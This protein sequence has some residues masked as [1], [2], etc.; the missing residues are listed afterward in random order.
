[1]VW[2]L[3]G[4]FS[5][6]DLQ[7]NRADPSGFG[8]GVKRARRPSVMRLLPGVKREISW[9]LAGRWI[10]HFK[11]LVMQKIMRHANIQTT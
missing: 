9:S 4:R 10:I 1:M 11:P 6:R 5:L 2:N 3:N 8:A 7:R